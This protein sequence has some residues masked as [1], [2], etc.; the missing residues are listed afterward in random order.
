MTLQNWLIVAII[1][2]T[3]GSVAIF[4]YYYGLKKISAMM[5]TIMELLFPITAILLDYFVNHHSL[6][7]AQWISAVVMIYA[8]IKL[9]LSKSDCT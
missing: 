1:S 5:A 9:N 4:I 6:S 7:F 3:S 2:L 8:I